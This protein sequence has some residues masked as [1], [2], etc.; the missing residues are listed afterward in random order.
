MP[1]LQTEASYCDSHA[2]QLQRLWNVRQ[3]LAALENDVRKVLAVKNW[4]AVGCMRHLDGPCE[5]A[6]ATGRCSPDAAVVTHED[7]VRSDRHG[8]RLRSTSSSR[9]WSATVEVEDE[10]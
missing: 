9:I 6:P 4:P 3:T 1:V 5:S 7:K 10:A 8:M 2:D